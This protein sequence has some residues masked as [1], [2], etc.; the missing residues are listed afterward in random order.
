V[1]NYTGTPL[2][3]EGTLAPPQLISNGQPALITSNSLSSWSFD[4]IDVIGG[5][6]ILALTNNNTGRAM[7]KMVPANGSSDYCSAQGVFAAECGLYPCISS[8]KTNITGGSLREDL[9]KT[10]TLPAVKQTTTPW[11]PN[12]PGPACFGMLQPSCLTETQRRNLSSHEISISNTS[13]WIPF[14]NAAIYGISPDCYFE[15]SQRSYYM[16]AG[17]FSS[18]LGSISGSSS[19]IFNGTVIA[20]NT[21]DSWSTVSGSAFLQNLYQSGNITLASFS[22]QFNRMA[23]SMT[24]FMRQNGAPGTAQFARGKVLKTTTCVKVRWGWIALPAVLALFTSIFLIATMYISNN[25]FVWKTSSLAVLFHGLTL[26]KDDL[27]SDLNSNSAMEQT[28]KNTEAILD[29]TTVTLQLA[30]TK[31]TTRRVGSTSTR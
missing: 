2:I 16:L 1:H 22:T 12:F 24:A 21:T 19:Q 9:M 8:Y 31:V 6:N 4:G 29:W 17:Y 10:E 11:Y 25:G 14:C 27:N 26:G 28:A 5:I 20:I 15:L 3:I 23:G 13:N 7:P 30:P 18:T